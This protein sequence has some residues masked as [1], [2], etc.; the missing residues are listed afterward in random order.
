MLQSANYE[1]QRLVEHEIQMLTSQYNNLINQ[2]DS[3]DKLKI[4]LLEI[5]ELQHKLPPEPV[6]IQTYYLQ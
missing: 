2:P 5:Q 6:V 1:T 3:F 4:I